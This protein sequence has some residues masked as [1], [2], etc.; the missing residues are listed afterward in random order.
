MKRRV[1]RSSFSIPT[2]S[3]GDIA[4]LLIIFFMVC[5][6]FAKEAHI[7]LKP[8]KALNLREI[9]ETP[10]AVTISRKGVIYLQGRQ[11]PDSMAIEWGIAGLLKDKV[12]KKG[13]TV[14]FK[15]DESVSCEIFE[16]ALDAIARGGGLIAA[17][18]DK[19]AEPIEPHE[20]RSA[21]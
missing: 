4:F 18:G 10:V 15:C 20:N 21:P 13:R 12:T 17:I 9:K 5:S 8:P 6:N 2:T 11:V 7:E 14:L 19:T 16:P 1:S 3:M